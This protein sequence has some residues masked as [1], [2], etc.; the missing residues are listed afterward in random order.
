MNNEL[1]K[2]AARYARQADIESLAREGVERALAA[3]RRAAELAS[4]QLDAVGGG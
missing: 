2:T 4:E 3:R 1:R